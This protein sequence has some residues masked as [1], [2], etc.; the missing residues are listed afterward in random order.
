MAAVFPLLV[1]MA[2]SAMIVQVGAVMYEL[3]GMERTQAK[4]Q[5][6]SAFT[7]T[8]FTTREAESALSIP[9]RR[10]IT[11]TLMVLGYGGAASVVA[12]VLRSVQVE[13][14]KETALNISVMALVL[15]SVW[16]VLSRHGRVVWLSDL[17]RRELTKR[18]TRDAVPHED[19]FSYKQGYGVTRIEVPKGSRVV[20]R[21]LRDLDL[22]QHRLQVLAIEEDGGHEILPVPHPDTV[23]TDRQHLILYGVMAEVQDVFAPETQDSTESGF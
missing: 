11:T 4:F 21:R 17:I 23:I 13:T 12:T 18:M 9:V 10:K 20:G 5:S 19:L 7:G 14:F 3:T 2:I 8:G 15:A 22:R 16:L 1:V 6:L